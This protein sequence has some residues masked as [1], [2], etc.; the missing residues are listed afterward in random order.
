M[1]ALLA[2]DDLSVEFHERGELTNRPLRGVSLEIAP[3][4]ILGVVGETGCGKSL[5]GLA[6]LG[7]LPSGARPSGRIVVDGQEQR[8]GEPSPLRGTAISIVFQNPGTAFNPVF[9]LGA[10]MDDVLLRHR[11]LDK[12]ER[13]ARVL[14]YLEQVGL[15]DPERVYRSYAH[16]L[17]GGMLQRAM[18]AMALV[19]EPRL[20][21]L[22]EPTTALDV[23]VAKQILDLVLSL[24]DRF[25][26][27]VM[28]ITHNLGVVREVCDRVAVLYAG[29]VIE[30]GATAQVLSDPRHPYTRGLMNALPAR[31]RQGSG[32]RRSPGRCP[33]AWSG[34]PAAPSPSGAR[35]RSTRAR[36]RIRCR[37][38][39]PGIPGTPRPAS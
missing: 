28:L 39:C 32:W 7:L 21:I 16:E 8:L 23:T 29:R 25:G 30:T 26:F 12:K 20:L 14:H 2:I 24:R 34:S 3:G 13:R 38:R 35:W 15:P 6:T 36:P 19:C 18:I 37:A 31:H 27:G 1:S 5:T 22:D 33:R 17:S 11:G 10:Q 9:T 4:E